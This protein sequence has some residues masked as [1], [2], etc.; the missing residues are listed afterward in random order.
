MPN[1]V[2]CAYFAARNY[3]YGKKE[4]NVFKE[5]IAGAQTARTINAVTKTGIIKNSFGLPAFFEKAA[6]IAQKIVYP[7]IIASG[8]YNTVKS[9]DKIKTGSEQA[10]GIATMYA[11]EKAAEKGLNKIDKCISNSNVFNKN[12][13]T[14]IGWYILKGAA[15]AGASLLGYS[16]GSKGAGAAVEKI[17][18]TGIKPNEPSG[19]SAEFPVENDI[20]PSQIE[21]QLFQDMELV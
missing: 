3:V 5:G 15:F 10:A 13:F 8:V 14:K 21:S 2:S 16:T 19:Q 18:Q 17:R 11:F 6:S 12:K 20:T 4:Q 9:D 1:G 7:L